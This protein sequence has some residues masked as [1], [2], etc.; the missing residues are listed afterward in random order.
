MEKSDPVAALQRILTATVVSLAA[1]EASDQQGIDMAYAYMVSMFHATPRNSIFA[2]PIS[3]LTLALE[4]IIEEPAKD[5]LIWEMTEEC[6]KELA[7]RLTKRIAKA[8]SK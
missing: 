3:C 2:H 6:T 8:K 1:D 4:L 5:D 7:G